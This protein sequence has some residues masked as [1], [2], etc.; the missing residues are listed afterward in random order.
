[1]LVRHWEWR[2]RQWVQWVAGGRWLRPSLAV[3][4]ALSFVRGPLSCA[5]V[6][7]SAPHIIVCR[8][9]CVPPSSCAAGVGGRD[10]RWPSSLLA[11]VLA[12]HGPGALLLCSVV[13]GV[14]SGDGVMVLS[15]RDGGGVVVVV[16]C[17]RPWACGVVVVMAGS[18]A[19]GS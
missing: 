11:V 9:C 13:L 18:A 6:R 7:P 14:G 4:H 5:T 16:T 19:A 1:M 3:V 8:R 10:R 12:D 17:Q 2:R 15:A